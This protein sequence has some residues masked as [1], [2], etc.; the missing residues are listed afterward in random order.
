MVDVVNDLN[1]EIKIQFPTKHAPNIYNMLE[2]DSQLSAKRVRIVGGGVSI[3]PG[4]IQIGAVEIKDMNS[5]LRAN[6]S[7]IP[8]DKG[9]MTNALNVNVVGVNPLAK[10]KNSLNFTQKQLAVPAGVEYTLLTLTV[11]PK[12]MLYLKS[13]MVT[14]INGEDA[15]FT[16]KVNDVEENLVRTSVAIPSVQVKIWDNDG[17]ELPVAPNETVKVTVLHDRLRPSAFSATIVGYF[18]DLE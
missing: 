1:N 3:N 8:I 7:Q 18:V 15:L 2:H 17:C 11:P 13:Y 6:V 9:G 4:D 12:K 10:Q 5:D 16:L 14:G